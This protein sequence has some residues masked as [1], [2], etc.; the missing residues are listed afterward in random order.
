MYQIMNNELATIRKIIQQAT[1]HPI[2]D[3]YIQKTEID[4]DKLVVSI[5][6]LAASSFSFDQS[7]QYIA[8]TILC[9]MA[10]ELHDTIT[11][12]VALK[13]K[14]IK[15][16]QLMVLAGDYYSA[17]SYCL[18]ADLDNSDPDLKDLDPLR[19]LSDALRDLN[20]YKVNAISADFQWQQIFDFFRDIECTIISKVA[21]VLEM[22]H[23]MPMLEHYFT[24][25]RVRHEIEQCH[26]GVPSH[27]LQ[28]IFERRPEKKKQFVQAAESFTEKLVRQV[29]KD[30]QE[31]SSFLWQLSLAKAHWNE[32]TMR[33]SMT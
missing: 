8:S 13:P 24:L 29:E 30:L 5:K 1:Q 19:N 16:R 10:F 3:R 20:A 14:D 4:E 31:G 21:T 28:P 15:A 25:K 18:I 9:Q 6:M 17:Q 11:L 33:L 23:W 22:E 7:D 12:D 32:Q 27:V 2:L 26:Q